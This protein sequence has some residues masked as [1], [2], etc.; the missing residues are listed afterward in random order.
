MTDSRRE[1]LLSAAFAIWGLAIA[2]SLASVWSQPAPPGQLPGLA[3]RFGFDADGPFR[4]IAG[5]IVLPI[6]L[7]LLL[8][9]VSRRLADAQPWARNTV[10]L[11][12][13]VA[14]W[15][16]LITRVP[17]WAILP[18]G[19]VIAI[20]TILRAR[21]LA[22][23]RRDIVLVPTFLAL[24][25]SLVD[26]TAL[27][28]DRAIVVAALI[29][30]LLR[31]ATALIPSP[32]APAFAFVAAPLGLVLQMNLFARDQRY[33]GWHAL[34]IAVIT[35]FILRVFLRN[36]RRAV[37]VLVFVT[38]PLSLAAYTNAISIQ[39]AEGKP[40]VNIFEDSHS[41]LPASEMLAGELPYRDIVP[42]HGLIEDGLFDYLVLKARGT[43]V[44]DTWKTRLTVGLLNAVALYALTWAMTGSAEAGFLAVLMAIM[45]NW[46]TPA[47][48]L[49]PPLVTLAL[50]CGAVR[51]RRLQWLRYAAIGTVACGATSLDF[52]AYTFLTFLVA[53][54]RF[55]GDRLKTLRAAATGIAI[56]VVPL[57]AGLAILGIFD[58]FLRTTFIEMLSL[59][60]V[61]TLTMFHPPDV[62]AN[63]RV[64]PEVL[65]G[66]FDRTGFLYVIWC[67]VVVFVATTIFRRPRRRYE[68]M[69]IV[70]VW[71]TLAA[72]SYA[73]RHHLY[74]ATAA[75]AFVVA[76]TWFALR[77]RNAFAPA[78]IVALL[79]VATPTSHFAVLASVRDA[80]GPV[81]E[82]W[83]EVPEIPRA[84]GG[85]FWHEDAA[86]LR[87][88]QKYAALALGPEE[89][90]LD[91]TNRGIFYFFLR[92]DCPI[93][94][95]EV[96]FYETEDRQRDV[97]RRLEN[98]M[99]IRAVLVPGYTGRYTV[100]GVPNQE[101]APLVWQYIQANFEPD[102]AEGDVVMWRRK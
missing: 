26:A 19:A 64:F 88:V 54:W 85:L 75:A 60:P 35:P 23:T 1:T 83:V 77:R 79:I 94:E 91:L 9:P 27:S 89:T 2:I 81:Q 59:A 5:L 68:P 48:R 102:F 44:G 95:P 66:L 86:A 78:M 51:L 56:G 52:G 69:V 101:R 72:I 82:G 17:L 34:A 58:D 28:V 33:F 100:D 71:I 57:F 46:F 10:L 3:T 37:V 67:V 84:K 21:D 24:V 45:T 43:T 53:V 98:D 76:S 61:Y 99:R 97:I 92:R 11:T 22:F 39:T 42:S 65:V 74:Y 25:T 16:V 14:I 31:V 93:R 73:E 15:F 55:P 12:P 8:R 7:P 70:A 87:G 50:L 49:L 32:I 40:R 90:W 4:F 41:L 63:A 29:V 96:A 13:L 30:L 62:F 80:R 6:L 36:A 38:Y 18:F 47:I 20:C